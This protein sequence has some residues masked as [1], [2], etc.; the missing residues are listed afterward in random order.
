MNAIEYFNLGRKY[1]DEEDYA[2]AIEFYFKAMEQIHD[3]E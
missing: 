1:H 3:P 2:K